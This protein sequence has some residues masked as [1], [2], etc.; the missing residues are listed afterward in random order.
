MRN[1]IFVF[2]VAMQYQFVPCESVVFITKWLFTQIIALVTHDNQYNID[3]IILN[4]FR[5]YCDWFMPILL[6]KHINMKFDYCL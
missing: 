4:S 2:E 5:L 3:H 6:M 1:Y